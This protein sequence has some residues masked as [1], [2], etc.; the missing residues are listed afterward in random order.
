MAALWI[1]WT[2]I[3]EALQKHIKHGILPVPQLLQYS[4]DKKGKQ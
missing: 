1:L 2:A 3:E 4:H